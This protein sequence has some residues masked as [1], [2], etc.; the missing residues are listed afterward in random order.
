NAMEIHQ[1][2]SFVKIADTGNLRKAAETLHISQSA[3]SSQIKF[4]ETRLDLKLFVRSAKGMELT[5]CGRALY[6]HALAVLSSA[7]IFTTKARELTGRTERR[8]KIGI[9]TDG[10]FLKVGNLS[11]LLNGHFQGIGFFFVSS[12][13]VRTPEMLRQELIDIGFFFGENRESDILAE[14]ISHFDIRIVIPQRLLP[15]AEITW[16]LLARLPWV[17]SVCDCPYYQLVQAKMESLGLAP[18][19]FVDAMDESVVRELVMDNQGIGIMRE[20]DARYAASLSGC[21]VW[22]AEKFSVPLSLGILEKNRFNP[23][24]EDIIRLVRQLWCGNPSDEAQ[25]N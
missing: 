16:E 15:E 17:W 12:E 4:L 7:E 8:I 9:N 1:L 5:E 20:D 22:E 14:T 10:R 6:P 2:K 19:R 24:Y 25:K 11:R 23:M 13:T 18:N 3:L 21:R